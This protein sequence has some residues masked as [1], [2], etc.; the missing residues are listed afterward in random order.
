MLSGLLIPEKKESVIQTHPKLYIIFCPIFYFW[1][2]LI[3]WITEL[4]LSS[5]FLYM[6]THINKNLYSYSLLSFRYPTWGNVLPISIIAF[7]ISQSWAVLIVHSQVLFTCK[8][9]ELPHFWKDIVCVQNRAEQRGGSFHEERSEITFDPWR[10][11][12]VI[13]LCVIHRTE[14]EE[15]AEVH[16]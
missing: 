6:Y 16:S 11:P 12:R 4:V 2:I 14:T 7:K 9:L 13:H 10:W 3:L 8:Y 15:R 1:D 5:A